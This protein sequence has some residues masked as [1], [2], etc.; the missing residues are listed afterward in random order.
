MNLRLD[1]EEPNFYFYMP[2]STETQ[3]EE[4]IKNLKTNTAPG[5]DNIRPIDIKSNSQIFSK[6]ISRII[7]LS[8][9]KGIFPEELKVSITRPIFKKGDAN[10]VNNYRPISILPVIEKIFEG[11]VVAHLRR[12]TGCYTTVRKKK[13]GL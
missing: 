10:D 5:N 8:L 9:R 1:P 4:L 3:I 11:Y 6:L 13:I 7:N 12:Y 2:Y